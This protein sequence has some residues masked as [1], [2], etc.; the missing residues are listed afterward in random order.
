MH[1]LW[2]FV[3]LRK[4]WKN[5]K[6]FKIYEILIFFQIFFLVWFVSKGLNMIESYFMLDFLCK[7]G[8]NHFCMAATNNILVVKYW[9]FYIRKI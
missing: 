7:F 4:F 5:M 6:I 9:I 2:L 8:F 3:S 1:A